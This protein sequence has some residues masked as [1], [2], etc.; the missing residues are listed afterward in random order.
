MARCGLAGRNA[1]HYPAIQLDSQVEVIHHSAPRQDERAL[2][3]ALLAALTVLE[4]SL[5]HE[6]R[7]DLAAWLDQ[8]TAS[9]I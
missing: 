7:H 2:H 9:R 8:E 5:H 4:C 6:K 3:L 1:E